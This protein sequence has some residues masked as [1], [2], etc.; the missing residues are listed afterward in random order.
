MVVFERIHELGMLL[1]IGMNKLRVFTMIMLETVMLT[2]T[3]A[4]VGMAISGILIAILHVN[5]INLSSVTKGMEAFG[6]DALVY[7]SISLGY[8]L[9][10]TLMVII[11]GLL[12][13][14]YPARKALKLN[15]VEAIREE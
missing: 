5:G 14:I 4:V 15:P 6:V 11:T 10:L 2:L 9:N 8:Y 12:A 3:G 13:S 1:A 7:P